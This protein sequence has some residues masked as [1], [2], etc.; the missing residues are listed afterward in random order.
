MRL[1]LASQSPRRVE[2]LR[3]AGYEFDVQPGEVD[4]SGQL[5]V[6][7]ALD[8]DTRSDRDA[9]TNHCVDAGTDRVE[10]VDAADRCVGRASCA[11]Y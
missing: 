10:R 2:L 1:I 9:E 8:R 5:T 3:T 4:E 6:V 7:T 11:V